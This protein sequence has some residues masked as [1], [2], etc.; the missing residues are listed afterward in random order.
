MNEC[1]TK[2]LDLK[3]ILPNGKFILKNYSYF[4]QYENGNKTDTILG[5]KY[6][7]LECSILEQLCVKV[8]K[9]N[10]LLTPKEFKELKES[11]GRVYVDFIN[12]RVTF[13]ESNGRISASVIAD[14]IVLN[15]EDEEINLWDLY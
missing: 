9:A 7:V 2:A 8:K 5:I 11:N 15:D 6:D 13:Y 14:N 3:S 1:L 12:A 10:P 4:Y